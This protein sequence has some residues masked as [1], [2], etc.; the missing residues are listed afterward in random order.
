MHGI[1]KFLR[2]IW[3]VIVFLSVWI[4]GCFIADSWLHLSVAWSM[5]TGVITYQIAYKLCDL[6]E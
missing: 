2:I 5:F 3:G 4:I 6:F 1:S